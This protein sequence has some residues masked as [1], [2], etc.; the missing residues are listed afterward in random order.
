MGSIGFRGIDFNFADLDFWFGPC[1]FNVQQAIIQVRAFN[2]DP[3][4]SDVIALKL[5][6]RYSTIKKTRLPTSSWR[7]R[8]TS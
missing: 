1:H 2:L 7:P 8:M 5:A 3:V 6:R 4:V